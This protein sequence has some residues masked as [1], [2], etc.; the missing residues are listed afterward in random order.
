MLGKIENKRISSFTI[1]QSKAIV[2]TLQISKYFIVS[3]VFNE[4]RKEKLKV[5]SRM[6]NLSQNVTYYS[7][8]YKRVSERRD[9]T[10]VLFQNPKNPGN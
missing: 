9:S 5:F 7:T 6:R 10:C 8:H 4:L 2:S 3:F 1:I